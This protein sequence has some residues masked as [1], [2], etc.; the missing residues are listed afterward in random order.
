MALYVTIY[1]IDFYSHAYIYNFC[2]ESNLLYDVFIC[3]ASEDKDNFVR[4]LAEAL[5][6]EHIEVWYDEFSLSVGDSLR[7]AIDRGL[8]SSRFGIV[9]FSPNFF[10]KS[11]ANHELNGLVSRHIS[12]GRSLILPVWHNVEHNDILEYSPSLADLVAISSASGIEAVVSDLLKKIRPSESPLNI[13]RDF[14]FDNGCIPPVIKDEWWLDIIEIK[15]KE[16][17]YPDLNQGWRW[18]FPLP[19]P[20]GSHGKER[21]LNIGWTALQLDWAEAGTI[22]NICQLTHPEIVYDF[23][24]K[25]PGLLECAHENPAT[26]AL[27]VPQLT[28]PGFDGDF[29]TEFDELMLPENN[30]LCD[31]SRYGSAETTDG[32]E[33]LCGDFIAWRHPSFGNYTAAELSYQFVTAHNVFY[34]RKVFS[35]FECLVWLLSDNSNWMPENLQKVLKQGFKD[36]VYWWI[37]DHYQYD[38][39]IIDMLMEHSRSKFA[40]TKALRNKLHDKCV[41]ALQEL[42]LDPHQAEKITNS[43]IEYGF[44]EGYY[45]EKDGIKEK[46]KIKK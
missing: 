1:W 34:S 10:Q 3:H 33:P 28:I 31:T 16:F 38:D 22:Q 45:D 37:T 32:N 24:E 42:K 2:G 46:R 19:Y 27:Y 8:L 17:L 30:R 44:L 43:F 40:Y 23:L 29:T 12:E 35:G 25:W 18:I 39:E 21:G 4:P 11:W 15:E 6:S 20:S 7:E 13:A 41:G 36:R 26:L 14:L 5:Q 9:V